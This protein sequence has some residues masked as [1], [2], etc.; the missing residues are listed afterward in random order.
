MGF[1]YSQ[2]PAYVSVG[3][4][5]RQ[6]EREIE[7]LRKKGK[8]VSPV[9]LEGNTIAKTFW[10]KAWCKN[11]ERYSDYANRIPRGRS[12]VRSGCVVDLQVAQGEASALVRGTSLYTVHVTVKRVEEARWQAIVKEC[13]G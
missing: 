8:D 11:L 1:G 3:D 4:R 6:A 13:A 12:Y 9:K 2:Y 5:R 10:G 7:K